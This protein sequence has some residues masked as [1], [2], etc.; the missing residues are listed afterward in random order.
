MIS[1]VKKKRYLLKRIGVTYSCCS[2]LSFSYYS[3]ISIDEAFETIWKRTVS[4][5]FYSREY[6]F[7]MNRKFG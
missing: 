1:A 5:D 2:A 7:S 6:E 3:V 4:S